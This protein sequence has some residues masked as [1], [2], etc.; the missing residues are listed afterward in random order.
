M[1]A[2]AEPRPLAVDAPTGP[3][4]EVRDGVAVVT[5]DDA[6]GC[7]RAALDRCPHRRAP[8][9]AGTV[10]G[11]VLRCPYHGWA[12]DGDGTC[13]DI[14][15]IGPE[16]RIPARARLAMVDHD[17]A[18]VGPAPD[19]EAVG[20]DDPRLRRFRHPIGLAGE[21]PPATA[22]LLGGRV[23]VDPSRLERALGLWWYAPDEPIGHL[24]VVEEEDDGRF[25]AVHSP[26]QVWAV[27]AGAAAE[28][29]LDLGHIPWLHRATFA[30][31]DAPPIPRLEV[32]DGEAGFEATY[33][34]R[35][36]RLH[37]RGVG[38]RHMVL[39]Y[40]APFSV[41][42]RLEY[43]DDDATITAGFF[44][45]PVA[46]GRTRVFAVNWRDDILDGRTTEQ[47]TIAFQ[48]AVGD[49]DRR[50]LELLPEGPHPLDPPADVHTRADAT[51][52]AMRRVLRR[53]LAV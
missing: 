18:A 20:C 8:L 1:T 46:A 2:P 39:R 35:T 40:T 31:P 27:E 44:L 51:T 34:H 13:V 3:R 7:T 5:W 17:G 49:E 22:E 48:Q 26:P 41:V 12:Y 30:D 24:P 28:N 33:A 45:Q 42:M 29:F 52:V 25:V 15:A 50:M 11:G 6:R 36:L 37:G 38:R 53:L 4:R 19:A 32:T 43:L 16:G 14:P 47:D 21:A 10:E 23:E 9:S